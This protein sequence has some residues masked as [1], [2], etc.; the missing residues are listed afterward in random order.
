MKTRPIQCADR[1]HIDYRQRNNYG[2]SGRIL[3]ISPI[4]ANVISVIFLS[5]INFIGA[6][7]LVFRAGRPCRGDADGVTGLVRSAFGARGGR[8]V[9]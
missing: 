1:G 7:T 5:V 6:D 2:R 4:V 8:L 9:L 3:H